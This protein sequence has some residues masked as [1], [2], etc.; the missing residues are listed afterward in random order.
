MTVAVR[1]AVRVVLA[2]GGGSREAAGEDVG[3]GPRQLASAPHDPLPFPLLP[4]NCS[5]FGPR[6][7]VIQAIRMGG[8][9]AKWYIIV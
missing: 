7:T 8:V 9:R 5:R 4:Q 2:R 6:N 3:Q 1:V